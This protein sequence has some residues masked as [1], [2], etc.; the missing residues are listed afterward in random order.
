MFLFSFNPV[1]WA[2]RWS[3]RSCTSDFFDGYGLVGGAPRAR[4][5]RSALTAGA[6]STPPG[7]AIRSCLG[8]WHGMTRD[9]RIPCFTNSS[10]PRSDQGQC[11]FSES[12]ASFV[13]D[14][15][16]STSLTGSVRT[17]RNTSVPCA[18]MKTSP[19]ATAAAGFVQ[20]TR[21]RLHQPRPQRRPKAPRRATVYASIADCARRRPP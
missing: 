11:H 3:A 6:Y 14:K 10:M 15:A 9:W 17:P 2:F 1:T 16:A 7:S 8:C 4:W 19:V 5:P 18:A 13:G 12:F 21:S 20:G